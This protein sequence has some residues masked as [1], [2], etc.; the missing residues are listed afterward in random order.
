MS[1]SV[2]VGYPDA[3]RSMTSVHGISVA[4]GTFPAQI[5][6]SYMSTA[7]AGTCETYPL[8]Q[9]PIQYQPFYGKYATQAPVVPINIPKDTT[10]KGGQSAGGGGYKGYDPR[11]Y[12]PGIQPKSGTGGKKKP[13]GTP[14]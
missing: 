12:A 11:A 10:K 1:T 5:W 8:P 7:I 3:L 2:W 14:P 13:G 4:G 6:H 9:N